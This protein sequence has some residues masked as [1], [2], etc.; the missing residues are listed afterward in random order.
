MAILA[1]PAGSARAPR[2]LCGCAAEQEVFNPP[3]VPYNSVSKYLSGSPNAV[4]ER[5]MANTLSLGGV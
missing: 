3:V 5:P 2:Q 1:K 4:L